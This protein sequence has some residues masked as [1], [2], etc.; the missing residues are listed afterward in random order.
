MRAL[1]FRRGVVTR[2]LPPN[3][4]GDM[5]EHWYDYF[6][7]TDDPP[8]FEASCCCGEWSAWQRR[9]D[10]VGRLFTAHIAEARAALVTEAVA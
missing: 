10:L 5:N 7:E 3:G 8:G 2:R 1:R 6:A 9:Q 4:E